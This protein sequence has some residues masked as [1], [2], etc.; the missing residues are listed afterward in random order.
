MSCEHCKNE[1]QAALDAENIRPGA[2]SPDFTAYVETARRYFDA[3]SWL[4]NAKAL[5]RDLCASIASS[6]YGTEPLDYRSDPTLVRRVYDE[7]RK[8]SVLLGVGTCAYCNTEEIDERCPDPR[9]E[10]NR[11]VPVRGRDHRGWVRQ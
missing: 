3:H 1:A 9:C 2:S 6:E 8:P 10:S 7:L 5:D 11:P 4:H